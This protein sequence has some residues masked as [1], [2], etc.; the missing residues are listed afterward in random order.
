MRGEP[1]YRAKCTEAQCKFLPG[2]WLS[3]LEGEATA[4]LVEHLTSSL[5]V[6]EAAAAHP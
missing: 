6:A 4:L 3:W 1:A 2:R 5:P